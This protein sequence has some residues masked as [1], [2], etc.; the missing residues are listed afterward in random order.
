[1]ILLKDAFCIVPV[2][3]KRYLPTR[4]ERREETFFALCLCNRPNLV[5][6]LSWAYKKPVAH[7]IN[8]PLVSVLMIAT[9][10]FVNGPY[11]LITTAVSANL[12]S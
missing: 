4:P 8:P 3:F 10:L 7:Y 5:S 11:A 12:V 6:G 2:S 1:M 9:G